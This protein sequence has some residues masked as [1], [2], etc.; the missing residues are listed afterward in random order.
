MKD[1]SWG[2]VLLAVLLTPFLVLPVL[3]AVYVVLVVIMDVGSEAFSYVQIATILSTCVVVGLFLA[4]RYR[5]EDDA[6]EYR[7][8]WLLVACVIPAVA[9]IPYAV[10]A[11]SQDLALYILLALYSEVAWVFLTVMLA[12]FIN[13]RRKRPGRLERSKVDVPR[14][15]NTIAMQLK[16]L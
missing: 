3:A 5:G 16:R 6:I 15:L 2:E 7:W 9:F 14:D 1:V 10:G 13:D 8:A 12:V 11:I 4:S